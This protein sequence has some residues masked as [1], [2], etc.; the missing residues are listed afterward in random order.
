[1]APTAWLPCWLA[2]ARG[3]IAFALAWTASTP[4]VRAQAPT[5]RLPCQLPPPGAGAGAGGRAHGGYDL[6]ALNALEPAYVR[7]TRAEHSSYTL[8]LCAATACAPAD[9]ASGEEPT[10]VWGLTFAA[11][12]NASNASIASNA[13]NATIDGNLELEGTCTRLGALGTQT[14]DPLPGAEGVLVSYSGGEPCGGG[15]LWSARVRVTCAPEA[16]VGSPVAA[17][18]DARAWGFECQALF[19]WPSQHGCALPRAPAPPPSP[20]PPG[21]LSPPGP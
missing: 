10:A 5:A 18:T 17:A 14:M 6:S 19:D 13:S 21:T 8:S 7:S 2:H 12:A 9:D 1:M 11:P 3:F 15:R 4:G 16:G 20:P